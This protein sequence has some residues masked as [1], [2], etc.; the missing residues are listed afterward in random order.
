MPVF[1]QPDIAAL[2]KEAE[3]LEPN[4]QEAA[5]ANIKSL[6]K[7]NLHMLR[8]CISAVSYAVL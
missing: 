4:N 2:L 6:L 5:F 3:R 8:P 1:A 7:L